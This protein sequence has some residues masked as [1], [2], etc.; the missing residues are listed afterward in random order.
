MNVDTRQKRQSTIAIGAL[1]MGP[2]LLPDGELAVIDWKVIGGSY[3]WTPDD[4]PSVIPTI[5]T[6]GAVNVMK[7]PVR[8]SYEKVPTRIN[9]VKV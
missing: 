1:F 4:P 5:S 9:Y 8:I 2:S 7:I 6:S 3:S